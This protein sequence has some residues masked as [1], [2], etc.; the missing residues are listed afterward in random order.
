MAGLPVSPSLGV[1]EGT[2]S[3]VHSHS[4]QTGPLYSPSSP[5]LSSGAASGARGSLP[6]GGG[7]GPSGRTAQVSGAAQGR[8]VL[9]L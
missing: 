6:S 1:S 4:S 2:Y 9:Q 7:K 3:H 8:E 5:D